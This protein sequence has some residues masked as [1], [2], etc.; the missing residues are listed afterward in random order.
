MLQKDPSRRAS[1]EEIEAHH[2]LQGLDSALLSPE[3]PPHW[4]SGTLSP[5]SP[6]AGLP[7]CGDL[8]AARPSAQQPFPGPCQPSLS[9]TLRPPTIEEPPVPKNLPAL[10]QICEEEEEEEEDEE[11]VTVGASLAKEAEGLTS[12]ISED[13]GGKATE[14]IDEA[15]DQERIEGEHKEGG[16]TG[17]VEITEEEEEQETG[18][19]DSGCVILDQPVS[20]GDRPL[21]QTPEAPPS[22]PPGFGPPCCQLLSESSS[23]ESEP[24]NNT[25]KPPPPLPLS[26]VPPIPLSSA[27]FILNEK[28]APKPGWEG[29][30]E[31]KTE[32]RREDPAT[33]RSQPQNAL[34]TRDEAAPKAEQG[35][36]HS[37]KLRERLFQFPL[38]EKALAFNIPTHNKPKILPLAQYNCCHVL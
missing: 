15:D 24:N 6:R 22:S 16:S 33:D 30:Q 4:L 17:L 34:G 13:S 3:A 36:R 11:E 10:Q 26:A 1:L 8:L 18:N 14:M 19:E 35:K 7:E 21:C 37:I 23:Q 28:D 20:H 9:F 12:V 32:G 2:W 29:D 38:C 27:T 31:Q 5:S 25:Q